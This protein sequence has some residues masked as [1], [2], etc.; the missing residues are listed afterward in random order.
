M[1]SSDLIQ[2]K[3]YQSISSIAQTAMNLVAHEVNQQDPVKDIL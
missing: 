1:V 2:N 3:D